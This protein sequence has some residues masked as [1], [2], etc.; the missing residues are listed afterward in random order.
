M[1]LKGY[2]NRIPTAAAA[3]R[4][5]TGFAC[6]RPSLLVSFGLTPETPSNSLM[7]RDKCQSVRGAANHSESFVGGYFFNQHR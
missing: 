5:I 3:T 6:W 1:L 7:L 4:R 2:T